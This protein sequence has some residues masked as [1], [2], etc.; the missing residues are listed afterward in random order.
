MSAAAMSQAYQV[1]RLRLECKRR[2]RQGL[3]STLFFRHMNSHRFDPD[4]EALQKE[5]EDWKTGDA[6]KRIDELR[7]R[8]PRLHDK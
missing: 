6:S 4:S 5:P 2:A 1:I 8:S 7:D 3:A